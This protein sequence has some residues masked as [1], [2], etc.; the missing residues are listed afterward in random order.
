MKRE[1]SKRKRIII[2]STNNPII[3]FIKHS[4]MNLKLMN[5]LAYSL[6]SWRMKKEKRK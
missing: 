6:L 1:K 2:W 5:L 3:E 4:P